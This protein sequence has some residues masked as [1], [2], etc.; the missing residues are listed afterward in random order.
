MFGYIR[1]WKPEL[2]VKEWEQYRAVYCG[3]CRRLGEVCGV[4]SRLSLSYDGTFLAMLLLGL[5]NGCAGYERGRC[6]VNPM[7]ECSYCLTQDDSLDLAAVLTVILAWYK[8]RDDRKDE[9]TGKKLL[10]SLLSPLAAPGHRR[11]A[12]R[13]PQLEELAQAYVSAQ[14]QAEQDPQAGLDACAEPTARLLEEALCFAVFRGGG[15]GGAQE[16]IL[17]QLGYHLGRWIYLMDAADDWKK[18]LRS[19]SFNPFVRKFSLSGEPEEETAVQLRGYANE[20][21]NMSMAQL[22]GAFA[23]L[24]LSQ[25]ETILRNIVTQGM[26]Q[27][28]RQILYQEKKENGDVGSV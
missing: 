6:V 22:G 15:E 2:L 4:V 5:G 3:L 17:R 14:A 20:T 21:L 12:R 19:G 24:E 18:D 25:F 23:L 13:F 7:K 26:P 9:R 10:A 1:P 27:M 16:R 8:L 11:A 28:Q